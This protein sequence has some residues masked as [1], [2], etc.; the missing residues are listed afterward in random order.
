MPQPKSFHLDGR[1][2]RLSPRVPAKQIEQMVSLIHIGTPDEG[3]EAAVRARTGA[4]PKPLADQ[5]VRYALM[6]HRR[7]QRLYHLVMG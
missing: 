7:N 5:A 1:R 2:Y 4:W 6:W 3:V